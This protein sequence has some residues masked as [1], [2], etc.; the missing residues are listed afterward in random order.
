L[1]AVVLRSDAV[2]KQLFASALDDHE[3]ESI[4]QGIYSAEATRQT[5]L[6][7]QQLAGDILNAGY[8]V[9]L[10]ATFSQPGY[11]EQFRQFASELGLP[12]VV[13]D[14]HAPMELLRERVLQRQHDI[15]DAD[16]RVL[17]H[18]LEH[19]RPLASDEA[20]HAVRVDA[21]QPLEAS[22]V[23]RRILALADAKPAATAS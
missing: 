9:I 14:I 20:D 23:A 8:S 16:V 1:N 10:D 2:R 17:E 13:I 7:L 18:Q 22:D 11:R 19:W 3:G 12:W 21:G 15:S 6:R 4:N 5:Y